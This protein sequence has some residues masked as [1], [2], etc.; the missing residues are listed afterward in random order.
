MIFCLLFH[1]GKSKS[2]PG[3]RANRKYFSDLYTKFFIMKK[4][5]FI[6]LLTPLFLSAQEPTGMNPLK[7]GV[8]S[9]ATLLPGSGIAG[10]INTPF[11]PGIMVTKEFKWR[12]TEKSKLFQNVNLGYSYHRLAQHSIFLFT[13]FGWRRTW[14]SGFSFETALGTGLV[15]AIPDVE[16]YALN[17]EGEYERTDRFGRLQ[18][19]ADV[20]FGIGYFV[21]KYHN[22]PIRIGLNYQVWFQ[23]PFVAEY[24]PVLPNTA[25]HLSATF[26]LPER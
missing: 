25:L 6:L 16:T 7:I 11:H 3:L 8:F 13:E 12:Q 14:E 17:D 21:N 15:H 23:F 9:N 22:F 24:V 10:I 2:P 1:Q 18:G 20:N 26:F 5:I 19:M 4:L